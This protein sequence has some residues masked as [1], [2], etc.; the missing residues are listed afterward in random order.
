MRVKLSPNAQR[1]ID[2]QLRSGD[3]VFDLSDR[4][5]IAQSIKRWIKRSDISKEITFHCARHTFATM[6][7]TRGADIYAI[8]KLIG[9]K[10][11]KT[12][13]IY[14]KLVD[15]RKDEAIDLLPTLG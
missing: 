15:K 5:T 8:S 10:D 2:S 13:Q 11:L 9:H 12:T 4:K 7:L 3:Y 6:L 1:I 14:A